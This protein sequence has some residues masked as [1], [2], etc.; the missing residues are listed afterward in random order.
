MA[1]QGPLGVGTGADDSSTGV[2]A[3][4]NPGNITADD[5]TYATAAITSVG[6]QTAV[7]HFLKA[8]NFGFSIPSGATID[9]VVAVFNRKC[10]LS[11]TA[12]CR[13]NSSQTAVKLV[14]GGSVTGNNKAGT[15][16]D[17][18]NG[19]DEDKSFGASNDLWGTTPTDSQVNASDFG[20]V[21]S[22]TQTVVGGT[23]TAYVDYVS[24][25][26]YYTAAAGG[27]GIQIQVAQPHIME[28]WR[29][30]NRF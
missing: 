11:G 26:V 24:I 10:V 6:F 4:S 3:W 15:N 13:D 9:G 1:S 27:S 14:I 29:W 21:I 22:A 7:T 25:T 30:D 28:M 20:V 12:I 19:S 23:S 2:T 18:S 5:G 16:V 17:W 8:T